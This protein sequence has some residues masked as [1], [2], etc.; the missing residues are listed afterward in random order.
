MSLDEIIDLFDNM[1]IDEFDNIF[2]QWEDI[3]FKIDDKYN[4]ECPSCNDSVVY[5]FDEIPGFFPPSWFR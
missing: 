4:V 2:N 3:K 1:D 5:S